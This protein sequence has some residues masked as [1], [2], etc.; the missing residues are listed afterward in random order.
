MC[1]WRGAAAARPPPA[2]RTGGSRCA[3]GWRGG[4][5]P[6]RTARPTSLQPTCRTTSVATCCARAWCGSMR[7]WT[8]LSWR[9]HRRPLPRV[10]CL[11]RQAPRRWCTLRQVGGGGE[12]EAAPSAVGCCRLLSCLQ[13][14]CMRRALLRPESKVCA[15]WLPMRDAGFV[16]QAAACGAAV[17]EFNLEATQ[18]TGLCQ[19]RCRPAGCLCMM[20]ACGRGGCHSCCCYGCCWPAVAAS[21]G[22]PP[23]GCCPLPPALATVCVPGQGGGA[24]ASR[25]WSGGGG[26]AADGAGSWPAGRVMCVLASSVTP[27]RAAGRVRRGSQ[28][29]QGGSAILVTDSVGALC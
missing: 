17:A 6:T 26:G 15:G 5:P 12:G 3:R 18:A 8:Q 22:F 9:R 20:P 2:G 7:A 23:S 4:A 28:A 14:S 1:A 29:A 25:V 24:A 10:I 16:H 13:R 21:P 11:S 19:V 27:S